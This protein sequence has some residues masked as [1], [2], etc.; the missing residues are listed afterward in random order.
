MRHISTIMKNNILFFILLIITAN[1]SAQKFISNSLFS[2]HN[3]KIILNE[4]VG[5]GTALSLSNNELNRI[6][7][8]KPAKL[9]IQI[10]FEG[11][12]L[13]LEL[14]RYYPLSNAFQVTI[15]TLTEKS[16]WY[17]YEE[18]LFFRG[19]IKDERKSFAAL[20]FFKE[21]V[22]GVIADVKS[23]ITIGSLKNNG[24][25]TNNYIMYRDKD[26]SAP[27][28]VKCLTAENENI[29]SQTKKEL[30]VLNANTI[31]CPV[32]IY[33]E[34]DYAAYL[35]N[36]S[37]ITKTVNFVA[38]IMNAVSVVYLNENI[39]LQLREVKVWTS[40]D[41]YTGIPDARGVLKAF[42]SNMSRG[43]N[44]DLAH[45]FSSRTMDGGVNGVSVVDVLC[46][47]DPGTRCG[48]TATLNT[49]TPT[50]DLNTYLV[51]H[52]LGHNFGSLHTNNC[53]WPGGA[54][55]N[56]AVP[57]GNCASGPPPVNGGTI[58][59]YCSINLA[60]GFGKL[61]GDKIRTQL[62]N[63]T[64]VCN[65]NNMEVTISAPNV[66]CGSTGSSTASVTGLTGAVS[67]LWDNGETT[68]SATRLIPG[69]HY[70]TVTSQSIS[71]CKI[72]KGVNVNGIVNPIPPKPVITRNSDTLFSS[73]QNGNQWFV[74]GIA[75]TGGI[76]NSYLARLEGK[77]TVQVTVNGC[78]SGFSDAYP[79]TMNDDV[80][81]YPNPFN[82]NLTINNNNNRKLLIVLVNVL[83]QNLLTELS[84]NSTILINVS[85]YPSANYILS[86]T[87]TDKNERIKKVLIKN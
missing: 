22:T 82:K 7:L 20:S 66:I 32:D 59:S 68:A 67:F 16:G 17:P 6:F 26:A 14:E 53:T 56:C 61:P 45:L 39:T 85:H 73:V 18:G 49:N 51:S 11:K 38:T 13:I 60:N 1:A 54:I 31:G 63:A 48:F 64:C 10:P 70:V 74:N 62:S 65:C 9:D 15:S 69:W 43:Y 37:N 30:K 87:D 28:A 47:P 12:T 29:L 21:E 76:N 57:E 80:K 19:K 27:F 52:E 36:G 41:P 2:T 44:G 71:G 75:I 34:A 50:S 42:R 86:I 77:Y 23:N 81:V 33:V 84:S 25:P 78:I 46:N 3:G 40:N 8:N 72:V 4:M 79:L 83:G 55:D 24:I 35:S 58:M 5:K